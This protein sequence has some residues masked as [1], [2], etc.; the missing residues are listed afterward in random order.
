MVAALF[1]IF[2]C[3][4]LTKEWSPIVH[5]EQEYHKMFPNYLLS[6]P[7]PTSPDITFKGIQSRIA[8]EIGI[9]EP[10]AISMATCPTKTSLP[11]SFVESYPNGVCGK[12]IRISHFLHHLEILLAT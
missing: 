3:L 11:V 4:V 1:H 12:I 10:T 6:K 5:E 8:R 2:R 7:E 9:K